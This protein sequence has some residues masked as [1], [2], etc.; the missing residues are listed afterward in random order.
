MFLG[1]FKVRYLFVTFRFCSEEKA[2]KKRRRSEEVT[3][4]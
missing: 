3:G 1:L 2:K 4:N